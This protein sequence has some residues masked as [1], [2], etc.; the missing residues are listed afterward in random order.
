M[1]EE[2]LEIIPEPD[3]KPSS[4]HPSDKRELLEAISTK[5]RAF[6]VDSRAGEAAALRILSSLEL[7]QIS[8]GEMPAE[9]ITPEYIYG[10]YQRNP[11][12]NAPSLSKALDEKEST[13]VSRRRN[14]PF[15]RCERCG[16]LVS[17]GTCTNCSHAVREIDMSSG[18]GRA[19][20]S[21]SDRTQF[22]FALDAILA[23]ST[24]PANVLAK[25]E[26]VAAYLRS[27]GFSDLNG[28]GIDISHF[29]SAFTA[30]RLN[31]DYIWCSAMRYLVTG[32]RP[33]PFSTEERELFYRY[34]TRAIAAFY[35]RMNQQGPD[36]KP[37]Q[38]NLWNVQATFKQVIISSPSLIAKHYDFFEALHTQNEWTE[39]VHCKVWNAI[40]TADEWEFK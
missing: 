17:G 32:I 16:G 20:E 12:L 26:E 1:D 9:R 3:F 7:L 40:W 14:I 31:N 21:N 15:L 8:I 10:I 13:R 34:Y 27:K 24:P 39:S 29:R 33:L 25:R 23:I 2:Y 30:V 35:R 5:R 37:L 6:S 18:K 19:A 4:S 38:R 22:D 28:V 11:C 36:G